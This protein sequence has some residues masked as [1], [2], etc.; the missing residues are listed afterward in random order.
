MQPLV[1]RF[2]Q[3]ER[4][5]FFYNEIGGSGRDAVRIFVDGQN[6]AFFFG[7]PENMLQGG[8]ERKEGRFGWGIHGKLQNALTK[9]FQVLPGAALH[10]HEENR[11]FVPDKLG[12]NRGFSYAAAI[13]D[14]ELKLV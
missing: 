11:L 14:H 2:L 8:L 3:I 13:N 6:Q 9:V 12:D 1:N 7:Q 4:V 5:L 10:A